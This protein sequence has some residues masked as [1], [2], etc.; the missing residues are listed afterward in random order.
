MSYFS[1]PR[2]KVHKK[3][4]IKKL[5]NLTSKYSRLYYKDRANDVDVDLPST[6]ANKILAEGQPLTDDIKSF[7]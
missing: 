7:C 4:E 5:T 2:G 3:E 6:S 1:L